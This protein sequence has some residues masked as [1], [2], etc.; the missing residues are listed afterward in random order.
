MNKLLK[1]VYHVITLD[2]LFPFQ[3]ARYKRR[4]LQ[5]RKIVFIEANLPELSNSL[6]YLYDRIGEEGGY[7]RKV[8]CLREAFAGKGTYIRN[9]LA[10]LKDMA[11]ARYIFLCEGSRLVGCIRPRKE[12]AIV[13]VWHGCGAFK[14]FGFSTSELL[15][16]GD[17][18]E[19]LRYSYY[20]NYDLVT[21]SSPEV[22]WA[23]REA[24]NLPPD[25]QI[26]Q[27][28][29]NSRT[30]VFFQEKFVREARARVLK[31][32]P[33]AEGKKVILYAPTFRGS[34]GGAKAPDQLDLSAMKEALGKDYVLLIKHH[35]V[36]KKRPELSKEVKGFAFDVSDTCTI[37]DLICISD[38]C[39]S[40]Y[41]SLIYEYS[42]MDRPMIFFAYDLEEYGDWRG[43]Y[44][45][46]EELTPGPVVRTTKELLSVI[47][48]DRFDR[49]R[50]RAFREKFMSACDGHATERLLTYIGILDSQENQNMQKNKEV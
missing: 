20:K 10:C 5:E 27:P 34:V 39:I 15:F 42:L 9:A 4:P 1:K 47:E 6:R 26:I 19:N 32:A 28:L 49:E 31:A 2:L 17:R 44:Y 3:Y 30:D 46:Y 35:P 24:M 50:I 25:S 41:S 48:E 36:I 40:D 38:L 7:V 18:K 29:G 14:R 11:A 22:V 16:G 12:T 21:V 13:Q 37:E 43:F 8:H 23:Y 33:Q 45:D